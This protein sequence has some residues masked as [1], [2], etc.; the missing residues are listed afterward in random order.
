[1]TVPAHSGN[2]NGGSQ[3]VAPVPVI[4]F[5]GA[6]HEHTE[7]GGFS[8]A[9]TQTVNQQ[10]FGPFDVPAFGFFRHLV[11]EVTTTAVGTIGTGVANADFP[12]SIFASISCL[13]VNGAPI[14][15]PFTG[16]ETL[17]ADISGGYVYNQDP[18]KGPNFSGNAISPS[19]ILRIPIEISHYDGLGSIANQ[20]AA[21]AYKVSLTVD[22]L[23]NA[24]STVGTL[25]APALLVRGWLEAWTLPD[26][27]DILGRPQAQFP[28]AHGTSQYW[29]KFTKA[30]VAGQNSLLLPRV[31]NL[32]R[33]IVLICRTAAGARADNVYLDPIRLAWDQRDLLNESQSLRIQEM[34][35]KYENLNTRDAGVFH[36]SFNH[37]VQG[38]TGDGPPNLW[39]PTMQSSRLEFSGVAAVAG[40]ITVLT[41]DV[42]PAEIRPDERFVE[43]SQSGGTPGAR[44]QVYGG[45]PAYQ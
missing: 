41:N 33:N 11:I 38:R 20:N 39:L 14:F 8:F 7:P 32:I 36:Y 23:A 24:Y 28:P 9:V 16:Y 4:P 12:F 31:G 18:R 6:A 40:S 3:A 25:V 10:N 27:A 19:F 5:T 15:G 26:D 37:S 35:E 22:S 13:D 34:F 43:T 2:Q 29:S 44:G 1:M 42:A 21:S 30:T 45:A 17:W